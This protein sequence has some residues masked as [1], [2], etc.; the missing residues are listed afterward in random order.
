MAAG[1]HRSQRGH[2]AIAPA[3]RRQPDAGR[4]GD[5]LYIAMTARGMD[6]NFLGNSYRDDNPA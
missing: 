6:I 1:K 2:T 5:G 4:R 3:R